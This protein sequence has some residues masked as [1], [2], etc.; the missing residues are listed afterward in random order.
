M[1]GQKFH[2][3]LYVALGTLAMGSGFLLYNWDFV[4]QRVGQEG[5]EVIREG[6]KSEDLQ[7]TA[8]DFSKVLLNGILQ[9]NKVWSFERKEKE[10]IDD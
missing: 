10:L 3:Y 2:R 5:A 1:T 6:I 9:D 8:S 7:I 4:K